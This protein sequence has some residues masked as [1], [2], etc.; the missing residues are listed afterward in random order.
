[1]HTHRGFLLPIF[2]RYSMRLILCH[3]FGE[4]VIAFLMLFFILEAIAAVGLALFMVV[5]MIREELSQS[6]PHPKK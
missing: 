4:K 5:R 2:R 1:M 6:R 3:V